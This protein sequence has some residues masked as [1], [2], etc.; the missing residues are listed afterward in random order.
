L[1]SDLQAIEEAQQGQ[2]GQLAAYATI[3]ANRKQQQALL[4]EEL[5]NTR[6]LVKEWY[7]PLNRQL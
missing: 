3:L 2:R 5:N 4:A 1:R 6:G 7:A